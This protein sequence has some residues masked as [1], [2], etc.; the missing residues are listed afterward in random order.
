MGTF[1]DNNTQISSQLMAA[2]LAGADVYR[3]NKT[4]GNDRAT[5][6][7]TLNSTNKRCVHRLN[8]SLGRRHIWY[9]HERFQYQ[10]LHEWFYSKNS[11]LDLKDNNR[12]KCYHIFGNK[13]HKKRANHTEVFQWFYGKLPTNMHSGRGYPGQTNYQWSKRAG[14]ETV[15]CDIRSAR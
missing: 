1:G 4:L 13:Y 10:H 7:M 2:I 8:F 6:D 11:N 12:E 15:I 9:Y 5:S 3:I 14:K